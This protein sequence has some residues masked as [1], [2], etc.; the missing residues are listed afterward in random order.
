MTKSWGEIKR[1]RPDTPERQ[2]AREGVIRPSHFWIDDSRWDLFMELTSTMADDCIP[3]RIPLDPQFPQELCQNIVW[4]LL[5]DSEMRP[6]LEELLERTPL[7]ADS[8]EE[9]Q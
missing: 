4:W 1:G 8:V 7:E 2:A 9:G 5:H 6:L 3:T